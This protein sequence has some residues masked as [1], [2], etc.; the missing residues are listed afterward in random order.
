MASYGNR[1]NT[2]GE[3]GTF[4]KNRLVRLYPLHLVMT[5]V[6]LAMPLITY[7]SNVVLTWVLTGNYAGDFAYPAEPW[8]N[9][10]GDL[11]M[12]QGFGFYDSLPLNF[13]SWS[14]G[15]IFFCSLILAITTYLRRG[16]TVAFLAIIAGATYLLAT[17]APNYMNST[18]DFGFVRCALNFFAGALAWSLWATMPSK[19][20]VQRWA[21]LGQSAAFV[22]FVG[23]MTGTAP[24]SMATM[25]SPLLAIAVL[26]AFSVDSGDYAQALQHRYF[27]WLSE[28][29]YSIFMTQASLL[30]IG[31]QT[32]EWLTY[33][34]VSAP[35]AGA[36]GRLS[37]AVYVG[38]L[39][40]V[41]N[42]TYHN[43]ELRFSNRKRNAPPAAQPPF[44]T[45]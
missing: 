11:V 14:I 1:L 26:L 19:P 39:L 29:S 38:R 9:I 2:L 28:R 30:F 25:L 33:F 24:M 23:F 17:Q 32:Q 18:F 3:C 20:A 34:A 31:H 15:C 8:K 43:I 7:A 44:T 40:V 5:A 45:A 6:V 10:L 37:L 16:R 42:W 13:P 22:V 36:I 27:T 4:L 12:L 21:V 35:A 41:A